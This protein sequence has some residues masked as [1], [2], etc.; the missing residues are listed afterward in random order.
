M[1]IITAERLDRTNLTSCLNEEVLMPPPPAVCPCSATLL[2]VI[3]FFVSWCRLYSWNFMKSYLDVLRCSCKFLKVPTD[4][5]RPAL[6]LRSGGI[7][8]WQTAMRPPCRPLTPNRSAPLRPMSTA[9]SSDCCHIFVVTLQMLLMMFYF[10]FCFVPPP[11]R[12]I[13]IFA[14]TGRYFK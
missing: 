3:T 9:H 10:F 5:H 1:E 14:I 6:L 7:P 11:I 13:C 4:L 2:Y 8:P 12:F